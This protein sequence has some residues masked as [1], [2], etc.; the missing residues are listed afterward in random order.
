LLSK[1]KNPLR[2]LRKFE[3]E[4][5]G[6]KSMPFYINWLWF[7]PMISF[8]C[9]LLFSVVKL[10]I[11]DMTEQEKLIGDLSFFCLIFGILFLVIWIVISASKINYELVKKNR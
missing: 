5:K 4:K 10:L 3:N 6:L 1:I 2:L 7:L 9:S 11:F 8:I